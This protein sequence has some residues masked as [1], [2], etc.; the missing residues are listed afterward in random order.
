MRG[1]IKSAINISRRRLSDGRPK[2]LHHKRMLISGS[3][4]KQRMP[5]WSESDVKVYQRLQ[6]PD[7]FPHFY[8][9][10]E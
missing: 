3:S 1:S 5:G 10:E 4:V 9:S 8:F 6:K 7:S 2:R